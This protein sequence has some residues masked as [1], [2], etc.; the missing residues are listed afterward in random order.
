MYAHVA[1]AQGFEEA[2]FGMGLSHGVTDL[3]MVSHGDLSHVADKLLKRADLLAQKDGGHNKF[4]ESIQVWIVIQAP[5]YW[6]QEFDTYRIGT[7]KQSESTM[8]TIMER[9]LVRG[10]FEDEEISVCQLEYI[11]DLRAVY[12]REKTRGDREAMDSIFLR[13]KRNLPEGFLQTRMVNAN[14]KVLRNIVAQRINHRL[15]EWQVFINALRELPKAEWINP[16][17]LEGDV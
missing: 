6:W 15:P 5:R 14:Y 7:T 1:T 4:L 2:L 12:L 3:S 11:N 8:H 10:D 13:M 17:L 9:D 16:K